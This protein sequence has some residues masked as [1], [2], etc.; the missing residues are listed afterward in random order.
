M[1]TLI[2]VL[3]VVISGCTI[4]YAQFV[5]TAPWG[6][7]SRLGGCPTQTP[8]LRLQGVSPDWLY[9]QVAVWDEVQQRNLGL[10]GPTLV[11][12]IAKHLPPFDSTE[13]AARKRTL[14]RIEAATDVVRVVTRSGESFEFEVPYFKN[15][16]SLIGDVVRM[17]VTVPLVGVA[18]QSLEIR[19]PS[20]MI[21]GKRVEGGVMSLNY[22]QRTQYGGC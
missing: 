4:N 18:P 1:R 17:E 7:P 10:K 15:E 22:V 11:F 6:S 8:A 13:A 20:F 2:A 9:I 19:V 14:I 12:I 16:F 5:P 3:A 21:D